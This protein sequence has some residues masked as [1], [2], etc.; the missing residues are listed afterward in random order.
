MISNKGELREWLAYERKLYPADSRIFRYLTYL[1]KSE[2]HYNLQKTSNIYVYIYHRIAYWLVNHRREKLGCLLGFEIGLN[3]CKRGLRIFHV[4]N[5]IIHS[6]AQI[7][8][9]CTIIGTTCLGK[10]GKE[11][12]PHIGK[13]CELGMNSV[14][15]GDVTIGNHV[16]IGAGAVVT[17]SFPEDNIVVAGVPARKIKNLLD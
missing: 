1:R 8:E 13:D 15:L 9:N 5:I 4:G 3:T 6:S 10:K 12:A 11:N 7:G 16:Y 17:K 2:Y 14:L